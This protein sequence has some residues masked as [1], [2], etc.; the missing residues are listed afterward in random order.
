MVTSALVVTLDDDESRD[1]TRTLADDARLTLGERV[2]L[3]LPVVAETLGLAAA[4][5]LTTEL[6]A[7][8]GVVSVDVVLVDFDPDA[9]VDGAPRFGRRRREERGEREESGHGPT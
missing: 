8:P 9:D 3:R 7:V 5:A 6:L 2:G 4:E 1:P